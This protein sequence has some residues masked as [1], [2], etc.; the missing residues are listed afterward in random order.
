MKNALITLFLTLSSSTFAQTGSVYLKCLTSGDHDPL[1][2]LIVE[3]YSEPND[4]C[5]RETL[6]DSLGI[7]HLK[8][9]PMGKNRIV[10]IGRLENAM[11]EVLVHVQE[12]Q[13]FQ[14]HL[15]FKKDFQTNSQN[16][17]STYEISKNGAVQNRPMANSVQRIPTMG[18][19][20]VQ[21]LQ[22]V[23][24]I[25]YRKP[26]VDRDGGASG[27]TVTREDIARLPSR[28]A[29]GIA[30]TVGG[31]YT[32]EGS[33]DIHMR[34]G[35]GNGNVYY[36]DGVRIR[37]ATNLPKSQINEVTVVTGGVPAKYGD[38]TGG[39]IDVTTVTRQSI[40]NDRRARTRAYEKK[41]PQSITPVIPNVPVKKV[42][43][44]PHVEPAVPEEPRFKDEFLPIYEN[45]FQSPL[46]HPNSTFGIDVDQA[47][48]TYVKTQKKLGRP[49]QRDAVKMEE[50]INSFDY[51][52][53]KRDTNL[54]SMGLQ[55]S[56][57][58]WNSAHQLFTVQL[59]AKDLPA[60]MERKPFNFVFLIDV[61]GSMS[62]SNKLG[63]LKQSF[64]R[65]VNTLNEKDKI[66][67]V[68]YAGRSGVVLPPTSCDNKNEILNAL[69]RLT[70]GGS[71]NGIGGITTAYTLAEEN[72]DPSYNNRI[73]LATDGDFNVGISSTT[74][75]EAYISQ[76]R[77]TGIYLTALGFGFGNYKNNIL[78]TLADKGDGNHFYINDL[79]ECI[80]VL[81]VNIGNL[82]TIARDVKI[83]V[84]FN[85]RLVANYRLIGY[86]NRLLKPK[87][88]DDDTKDA[89]EIGYG[90]TVTAVYE[91]ELGKAEGLE[92][93]FVNERAKFGKQELA[94][95]K[96]RHKRGE[97]K[98]SK[99]ERFSLMNDVQFMEDPLLNLVT[100]YGLFLRGSMFKGNVDQR[101]LVNLIEKLNASE[102]TEK[103]Q[104]NSRTD[105]DDQWV[106]IIRNK[107]SSGAMSEDLI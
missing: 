98:V 56:A 96:L 72:Y 67:I 92:N 15:F 19:A 37:G 38:A 88:F 107:K 102:N 49:V 21:D 85:P 26:L 86:E 89:G 7:V 10:F 6:T 80:K 28:S 47:S 48:W 95:V 3:V 82:I 36:V 34:G 46:S 18:S 22:S 16:S 44:K 76:K 55:R 39:I 83:N 93:R 77:G 20:N 40:E 91:I 99:E 4:S 75:L 12:G 94:Y 31:V 69:D 84:E 105:C 78:E 71:T 13:C 23:Q 5:A 33:N 70:S 61:S 68:T 2:S 63:L 97:A 35:R 54:I 45:E 17:N 50:M 79:Q 27:A 103:Q 14:N 42:V 51:N 29:S 32:D 30:S 59:K 74:D 106:E 101:L 9:L 66:S 24:I 58:P 8:D 52:I 65:F 64:N 104:R 1:D 60:N 43:S 41:H 62:S 100:A 11:S 81:S 53:A 73:L 87:D 90:H 57:C 25:S